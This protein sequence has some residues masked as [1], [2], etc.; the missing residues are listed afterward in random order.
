[1][2]P[3]HAHAGQVRYPDV[4]GVV[5]AGGESLRMGRDKALMLIRGQTLVERLADRLR[6][7][8]DLVYI[9]ANE[10]LR[11]SFLGLPVIPDLFPG[12]GPLAG[13]HAVLLHSP[14]P[15]LLVLACDLPAVSA[16][17]L[18]RLIA[19]SNG[20]DGVIPATSDG[21]PHPVCALYHR[22]CLSHIDRSLRVGEFG[23]LRVLE[24]SG[25][26]IRRLASPEGRFADSELIDLDSP[27]D[28]ENYLRLLNS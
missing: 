16:T 20:Y 3:A 14:R 25:L 4:A 8:T 6:E 10:P 13:I 26:Q 12:T 9:S 1:M 11:Y 28:C 7:V 22:N 17:F 15:W 21:F 18:H 23:I 27:E 19:S 2:I 5:L 24:K